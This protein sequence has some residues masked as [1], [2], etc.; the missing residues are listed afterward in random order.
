MDE[1]DMRSLYLYIK[2]LGSPGA[3]SCLVPAFAGAD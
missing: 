2:S 1:S 3:P